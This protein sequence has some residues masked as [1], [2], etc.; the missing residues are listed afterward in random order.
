LTRPLPESLDEGLMA[1]ALLHGYLTVGR[2][3]P[4]YKLVDIAC[5]TRIGASREEIWPA[6]EDPKVLG[7][8]LSF[9][10]ETELRNVEPGEITQRLQYK[11]RFGPLKKR[12]NYVRQAKI[13]KPDWARTIKANLD[14]HPAV[15]NET[16]WDSEGDTLLCQVYYFDLKT[17]WLSAL[18]LRRHAEFERLIATYSPS[19]FVR[20]IRRLHGPPRVS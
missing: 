13:Q 8:F 7:D 1:P 15:Q 6:I 5:A 16:L 17:D 12:Y 10:T 14:G 11:I 2:M 20:S 19:V 4:D 3:D 18:F 9:I